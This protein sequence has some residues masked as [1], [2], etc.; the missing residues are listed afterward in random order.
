MKVI[1]ASDHGGYQLK[2]ELKPY[3][4]ELGHEVVD[5]GTY[6]PDPVDYPDFAFIVAEAVIRDPQTVGIV[7]DGAGIGSAIAANK[8]PGV[9]AAVCNDIFS[10]RNSREHNDANVLT[11]GGRVIGTGLAREIVRV[12]LSSQFLGFHHTHRVK[13]IQDIERKFLKG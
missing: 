11:M 5:Y 9:R 8:V 3:I 2:E 10:A 1:V 13:K 12:W 4:R 6:S 7:V